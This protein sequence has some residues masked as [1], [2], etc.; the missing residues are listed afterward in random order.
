MHLEASIRIDGDKRVVSG[1]LYILFKSVPLTG[2]RCV[3]FIVSLVV[4]LVACFLAS[5]AVSPPAK[6]D[7]PN[8]QQRTEERRAIVGPLRP[9]TASQRLTR[10]DW[11]YHKL[12]HP[13]NTFTVRTDVV[14][15]HASWDYKAMEA[16]RGLFAA[17]DACWVGVKWLACGNQD[18]RRCKVWM[19]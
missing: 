18:T 16:T 1:Y 5:M 2:R 8:E 9:M 10:G 7:T 19:Y 13:C 17:H 4:V 11:A 15:I 3:F 12:T 14:S 6:R